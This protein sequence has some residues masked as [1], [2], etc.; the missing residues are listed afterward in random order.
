MSYGGAVVR[1]LSAQVPQIGGRVARDLAPDNAV[2]PFITYKDPVASPPALL[3]DQKVMARRTRIQVDLW[4]NQDQMDQLGETGEDDTIAPA[5]L[6]ALNG[7][8]LNQ[9]NPPSRVQRCWV[10]DYHRLPDPEDKVVHVSF[11]IAIVHSGDG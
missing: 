9:W 11:D 2:Y 10:L 1:L 3:G 7:C 6:A 4:Q 8:D 5:I